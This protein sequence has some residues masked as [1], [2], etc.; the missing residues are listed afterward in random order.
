MHVSIMI[1]KAAVVFLT[2]ALMA[3]LDF[4]IAH[5]DAI[6]PDPGEIPC[7]GKAVGDACTDG[8]TG[9]A[10][11]CQNSTCTY[12]YRGGP[13]FERGCLRC[14]PGDANSGCSIGAGTLPKR[15]GPWV[16]AGTFSSLFLFSRRR[17]RRENLQKDRPRP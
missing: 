17:S 2:I 14:T 11:K 16:L 15:L 10:G 13:P 12:S 3:G 1:M 5:A 9:A 8:A 6:A 4:S 7:S